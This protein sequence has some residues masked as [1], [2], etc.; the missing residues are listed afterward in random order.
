[1]NGIHEKKACSKL[2]KHGKLAMLKLRR[3]LHETSAVTATLHN[4][5]PD[6]GA[7]QKFPCDVQH[8]DQYLRHTCL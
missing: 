8:K 5:A 4:V 1:M 7:L 3:R 2:S 6:G